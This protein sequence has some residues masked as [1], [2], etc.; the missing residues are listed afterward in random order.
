MPTTEKCVAFEDKIRFN[1]Y[2]LVIVNIT[3]A[4]RKFL[5]VVPAGN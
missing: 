2:T 5:G 3:D 1:L 4:K